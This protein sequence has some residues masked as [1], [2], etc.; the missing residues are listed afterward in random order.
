MFKSVDQPI[1]LNKVQ[2]PV[3]KPCERGWKDKSQQRTGDG[4]MGQK[5][6]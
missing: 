1:Q 6:I 4:Y 2:E 5:R 3:C